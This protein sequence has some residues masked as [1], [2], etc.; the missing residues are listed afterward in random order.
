[1]KA[2]SLVKRRLL[3]AGFIPTILL[4][5]PAGAI[6]GMAIQG[7]QQPFEGMLLGIIIGFVAMLW[8]VAFTVIAWQHQK[9]LQIKMALIAF[10]IIDFWWIFISLYKNLLNHV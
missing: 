5:T 8:A 2:P 10:L 9:R 7:S 1:M 4:L 3:I 6:W